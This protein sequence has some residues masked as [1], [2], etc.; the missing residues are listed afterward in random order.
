METIGIALAFVG[1][2]LAV[3]LACSGSARGVGS[4]GD[5]GAR[6][7]ANEPGKVSEILCLQMM[8]GHEELW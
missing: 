3:G 6:I 8:A 4:G 2:A 1:A 7:L 5:G